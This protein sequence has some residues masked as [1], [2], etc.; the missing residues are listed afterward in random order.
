MGYYSEVRAMKDL[1]GTQ[2][3]NSTIPSQEKCQG[4]Y[5]ETS[6]Y[7]D[8]QGNLHCSKCN[9]KT[10]RY[11][12]SCAES[13]QKEGEKINEDHTKKKRHKDSHSEG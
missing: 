10:K 11:V 9:H 5:E 6:L 7:D 13:V 8:W 2:C 1:M 12:V 4:R 3:I